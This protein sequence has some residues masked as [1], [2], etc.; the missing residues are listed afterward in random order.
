MGDVDRSDHALDERDL[1]RDKR[2]C[3]HS[4]SDQQ[5]RVDRFARDLAA[6]RHIDTRATTRSNHLFHEIQDRR[7][8]AC[9]KIG[10]TLVAAVDRQRV[11]DEVVGADREERALVGECARHQRGAR[12]LDH[13]SGLDRAIEGDAF[14][15]ELFTNIV[16]DHLRLSQLHQG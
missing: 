7:R 4:Q 8:R 5:H 13:D 6:K 1:T 9:V 2:E 12:H 16:Q 3:T 10:N 11:L 14:F 15:V